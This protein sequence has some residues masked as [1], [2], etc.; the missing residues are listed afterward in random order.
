MVRAT[1]QHEAPLLVVR[2]G[3][4][5]ASTTA[6]ARRTPRKKVTDVRST[7]CLAGRALALV[8]AGGRGLRHPGSHRRLVALRRLLARPRGV[9]RLQA[10]PRDREPRRRSACGRP[11]RARGLPAGAPRSRLPASAGASPRGAHAARS[12]GPPAPAAPRGALT[13]TL[14]VGFQAA[15]RNRF[16]TNAANLKAARA[17]RGEATRASS[18]AREPTAPAPCSA[19]GSLRCCTG[20][21]TTRRPPCGAASFGTLR[22][23]DRDRCMRGRRKPPS[24]RRGERPRHAR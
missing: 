9:P 15:T 11:A 21:G 10:G 20:C 5:P 2:R 13:P 7:N 12:G 6:L 3:P 4:S 18:D 16:K 24:T 8:V 23:P 22:A 19:C 17:T 1:S 14:R